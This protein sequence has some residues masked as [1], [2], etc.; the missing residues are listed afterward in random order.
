MKFIGIIP[1]RYDSN[2]FPG[3]PLVEISGKTMIQRTY[4]QSIKSNQLMDVIVA[5]DDYRIFDHVSEFGRVIMTKK[6]HN[7]GT[8]RCL[9][10]LNIINKENYSQYNDFDY[11]INIQGDEPF[12]N[13]KQIDLLINFFKKNNN[14]EVTTLIKKINSYE[15]FINPNIVKVVFSKNKK[16]LYFSRTPIPHQKEKINCFGYKHIGLYGYKIKTLKLINKIK[17]SNLENLESLEQLKWLENDF[18][19]HVVETDIETLSIDTPNDLNKANNLF[20]S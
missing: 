7:S 11:V 20:S 15:E 9:E 6:T 18:D 13:P 8:E 2:R 1:A 4:E 17:S 19:V 5:T 10:A 3:K 14:V 12:I 16:A